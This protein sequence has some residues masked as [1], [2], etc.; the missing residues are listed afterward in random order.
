MVLRLKASKSV[1]MAI[2]KDTFRLRFPE[3]AEEAE[4]C[5]ERIQLFIDDAI[6]DMGTDENRWCGKYDRA[7]AYL[8]AHLLTLGT[9]QEAGDSS[10]RVGP[11]QSKAAGGVSVTRAVAQ[12][13]RSDA[14]DLY[15]STSYG[16]QF[17]AIRNTCFVGVVVAS[18]L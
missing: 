4:F 14:D 6:I 1:S 7:Q 9:T 3:Y 16:I 17:L 5:D 11:I 10:A 15:S 8:A 2:T 13:N 18:E 12:K